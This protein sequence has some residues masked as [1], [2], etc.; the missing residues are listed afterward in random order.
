MPGLQLF[1]LDA[2]LARARP[3]MLDQ[4]R[5]FR[6][7]TRDVASWP[8][9]VTVLGEALWAELVQLRI[10]VWR[11][12]LGPGLENFTAD[13]RRCLSDRRSAAAELR[14]SAIVDAVELGLTGDV[15]AIAEHSADGDTAQIGRIQCVLIEGIGPNETDRALVLYYMTYRRR[16]PRGASLGHGTERVEVNQLCDW[17]AAELAALQHA[18]GS[19]SPYR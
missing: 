7:D 1:P 14:G 11:D 17:A 4:L 8:D 3:P 13:V 18:A 15:S 2:L 5:R 16:P 12:T 6:F 19:T 9:P 10:A